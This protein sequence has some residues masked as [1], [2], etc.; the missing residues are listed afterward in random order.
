MD[1]SC[2]TS[3][4][5]ASRP[6]VVMPYMAH[7]DH[8]VPG[9]PGSCMKRRDGD[10]PCAVVVHHWRSRKTG[11]CFSLCVARCETHAVAFTLY[12]PGHVP[13]GRVAIAP[14]SSDGQ[15]VGIAVDEHPVPSAAWELTVF[16]ATCDAACGRAWPRVGGEGQGTFRTQCRRTTLAA[17]L[18][19]A[20]VKTDAEQLDVAAALRVPALTL[21]D[22]S[23]AFQKPSRPRYTQR[24]KALIAPL[25]ELSGAGDVLGR[26]LEAGVL[27]GQ[28]GIPYRWDPLARI[29][30]A[31]TR[32][33]APP[34]P[35][36]GSG[37]I[38]K[39]AS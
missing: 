30:R 10:A 8:L 4:P 14:V 3:R 27:L 20:S 38:H 5:R 15:P 25:T 11:P 19:G 7:D 9:L 23:R 6:F 22:A 31:W 1:R 36:S 35:I 17:T 39:F 21:R 28:W 13:Y 2:H 34:R 12:P 33:R 26:I 16:R 29:L 32:T 37:E 18:L 24:A